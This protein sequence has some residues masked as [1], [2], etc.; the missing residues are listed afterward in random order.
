MTSTGPNR[1]VLLLKNPKSGQGNSDV[2]AFADVLRARGHEI[3]ERLLDDPERNPE[4]VR[5]AREFG[6]L[7]A[8]GG[9]GTVSSIA[10]EARGMEVPLLA[11]PAGTAN[12]IAQNLNLP[13]DVEALAD[14]VDAGH[15][16]RTDL[17][18]WQAGDRRWGFTL[19]AGAGFD[20]RMIEDSEALKPKL[21]VA[22]Y[23]LSAVKELAPKQVDFRL[24]LDGKVVEARGMSVM[25]A[26]FGMANFRLPLTTGVDPSDGRL[27]VIVMKGR[28]ALSL[29]PTLIDSVRA[30]LDL[31][32]PVFDGNL[33]TYECR[34]ALLDA[35][36]QLPLQYDGEV[37]H[38]ALPATVRVLPG[39]ARFLTLASH[40]EVT[41]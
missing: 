16:V 32:D 3:V 19:I 11:F 5:D 15:T 2:D 34:E 12:L 40:E 21:G 39:A 38:A 9:D 35:D 6:T 29:L 27:T 41:T 22:A 25:F 18:E 20:A 31:G 33:E 17:A 26:N 36:E 10:Y 30:R 28:T 8:A 4:H 7:V 37:L 1:R 24:T 13:S 14:I 23:V